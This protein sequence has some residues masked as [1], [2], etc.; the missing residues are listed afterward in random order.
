MAE[1]ALAPVP[2]PEEF[3]SIDWD[4]LGLRSYEATLHAVTVEL[5][6]PLDR[7]AV[8]ELRIKAVATFVGA[9]TDQ[10]QKTTLKAISA[11]LG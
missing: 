2:D 7:G 3:A 6:E 9:G 1:P 4:S 5:A 11:V 10:R 8:V